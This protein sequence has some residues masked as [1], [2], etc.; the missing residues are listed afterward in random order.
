VFRVLIEAGPRGKP[1]GEIAERVGV[2]KNTLSSHLSVLQHAELISRRQVGRSLIYSVQ[3]DKVA[4]MM[5]T[6]VADCCAGHP[7]VC[8]PIQ[9]LS[10][11]K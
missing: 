6:L 7:E 11:R 2:A 1:A 8:A 4:D 9:E 3:I 5:R 10:T